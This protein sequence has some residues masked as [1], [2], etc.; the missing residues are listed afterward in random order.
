MAGADGIAAECL[1]NFNLSFECPSVDHRAQRAQVAVIA[2]AVDRHVLAVQQESVV[3][4][5]FNR[6]DA[7]RGFAGKGRSWCLSSQLVDSPTPPFSIQ[8]FPF[9]TRSFFSSKSAR[10]F[11]RS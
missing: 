8:P 4:R 5:E 11:L 10:S 2:N 6:A 7:E 3:R 1:Q 9:R